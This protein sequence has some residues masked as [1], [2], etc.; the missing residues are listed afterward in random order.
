MTTTRTR[1]TLMKNQPFRDLLFRSV[2]EG[3]MKGENNAAGEF[4]LT[5]SVDSTVVVDLQVHPNTR[6]IAFANTSTAAVATVWIP[7]VTIL[8]GQFTVKHD[9]SAAADRTFS[10]LLGG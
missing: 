6:P 8:E 1:R 3:L 7:Q 4:T 9:S 10:Y 2:I 5:A